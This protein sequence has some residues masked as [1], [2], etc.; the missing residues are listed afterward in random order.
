MVN[1][2]DLKIYLPWP[3]KF[4]SVKLDLLLHSLALTVKLAF[5]KQFYGD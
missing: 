1:L 5:L 4:T 3:T 2:Q